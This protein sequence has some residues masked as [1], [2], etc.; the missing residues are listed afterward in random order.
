MVIRT[1][2]LLAACFGF[3]SA[4]V[5]IYRREGE[6]IVGKIISANAHSIKAVIGTGDTVAIPIENI[7][8]IAMDERLNTGPFDEKAMQAYVQPLDSAARN[9]DPVMPKPSHTG[10]NRSI[11]SIE[12]GSGPLCSYARRKIRHRDFDVCRDMQ[13]NAVVKQEWQAAYQTTTT[14]IVVGIAAGFGSALLINAAITNASKNV[15][16]CVSSVFG[17]SENCSEK[18]VLVFVLT[19]SL[20]A[21]VA[22]SAS[23]WPNPSLEQSLYRIRKRRDR[24]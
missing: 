19:G 6:E 15:S 18:P 12:A 17:P 2:T 22:I 11:G 23:I 20:S 4:N 1:I 9:A 7:A 13:E 16:T 24:D 8:G 14:K 5:L 10:E 3:S 21:V